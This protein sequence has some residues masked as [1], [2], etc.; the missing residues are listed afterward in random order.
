MGQ[1]KTADLDLP[2]SIALSFQEAIDRGWDGVLD[3]EGK[4]YLVLAIE[5]DPVSGIGTIRV[6]KL[7]GAPAR[8]EREQRKTT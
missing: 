2:A 4:P 8:A 5:I 6:S 1:L 7:R 3:W